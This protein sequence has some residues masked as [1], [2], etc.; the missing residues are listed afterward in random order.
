[1]RQKEDLLVFKPV[2]QNRIFQDVVEQVE[3]AIIDGQLTA[4]E[5]LPSEREL[6]ETFSI[7]RGTLREALRVLEQKR[8]IDI[9]LGAGGG[10]IVREITSEVMVD[11]LSL[12][13]R[14][15]QI[16]LA[17]LQEFRT[18]IEGNIARLAAERATPEDVAGLR[19]ILKEAKGS[20][21]RHEQWEAYVDADAR[22]HMNLAQI[23]GNA[24]Y[25]YIQT[26]IHEN[27]N[28]Y[29]AE[30]LEKEESLLCH[31][32]EDLCSIVDAVAGGDGDKACACMRKHLSR[33]GQ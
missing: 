5:K 8:L 1:L 12:L 4:G 15:R 31:H 24:V 13:V 9:E 30:F 26:G 27:I 18:D 3:D 28:R 17:H 25:E 33:L 16:P 29:Y 21:D 20:L 10:S 11:G 14:S 7:S 22:L 32:Y 19:D 6:K 2:K 23:S